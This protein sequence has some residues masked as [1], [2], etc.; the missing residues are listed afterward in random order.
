MSDKVNRLTLYELW[1]GVQEAARKF[2]VGTEWQHYGGDVYEITGH[3]VDEETGQPEVRY[4]RARPLDDGRPMI[5]C[6]IGDIPPDLARQIEFHRLLSVFEAPVEKPIY[7][8]GRSEPVDI[9]KGGPRYR[10]VHRCEHFERSNG[11][12]T[13]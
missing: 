6:A 7:A 4:I 13:A 8:V 12:R 5:R 2:P 1:R 11:Q 10:R 9:I 3:G